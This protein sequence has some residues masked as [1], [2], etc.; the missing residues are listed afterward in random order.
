[1]YLLLLLEKRKSK[2]K[3][4]LRKHMEMDHGPGDNITHIDDDDMALAFFLF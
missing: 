2:I 4:C 3:Y 1:M